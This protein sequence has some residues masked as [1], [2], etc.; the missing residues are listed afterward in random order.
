[1]R[2]TS[3]APRATHEALIA[4]GFLADLAADD[5]AI[6]VVVVTARLLVPL[7][8]RASTGRRSA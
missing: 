3:P 5:T 7:T 8:T 6:V 1:V 2:A 4:P